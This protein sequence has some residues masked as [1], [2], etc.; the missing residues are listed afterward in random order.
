VA[1]LLDRVIEG[2]SEDAPISQL[3][4]QVKVIAARTETPVLEAWVEHELGGYPDNVEVPTYRG[5]YRVRP[6]GHF[7]C[8]PAFG[9]DATNVEIPRMS[10]PEK[11]RDGNL[12]NRV[13]DEPMETIEEWAK[14]EH[15][16]FGWSADSVQLYNHMTQRGDIQRVL[17]DWYM[18]AE[19]RYH[20]DAGNLAKITGAV[21]S[22]ILD[23]A[24]DLER[25]APMAGQREAPADQAAPAAAVI[26]N[27][28]HAPASVAIGGDATQIVL[29]VPARGDAPALLR[30]L[31][32]AGMP[33]EWLSEL[34]EQLHADQEADDPAAEPA[35]KWSRTRSWL[36]RAA[37]ETTSGALGGA[38]VAA[39]EAFLT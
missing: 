16:Q 21:R 38:I 3:L 29:D 10:F 23:L 14:S 30:Y 37:S 36:A 7:V 34:E 9:G 26:N 32:A 22:K 8:A 20:I 24:L 13:F 19:V 4:R 33:T 5:P 35:V 12:F 39:A 31:G 1:T 17:Q 15:T 18:L 28:F 6:L 11:Y 25:V 27:H 2:A